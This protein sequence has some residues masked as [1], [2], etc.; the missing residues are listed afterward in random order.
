MEGAR[1]SRMEVGCKAFTGAR[2]TS[3]WKRGRGWAPHRIEGGQS[4]G[5]TLKGR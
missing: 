4:W 5:R 1:P 3:L 2:P